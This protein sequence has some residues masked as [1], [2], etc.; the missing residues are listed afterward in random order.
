MDALTLPKAIDQFSG[1]RQYHDKV[2]S[3]R[4]GMLSCARSG[5]QP[6]SMGVLGCRSCVAIVGC[7]SEGNESCCTGNEIEGKANVQDELG[8]HYSSISIEIIVCRMSR[9]MKL[10]VAYL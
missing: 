10:R 3:G 2:V 7:S 9:N 4:I 6:G 1:L 8:E 5:E